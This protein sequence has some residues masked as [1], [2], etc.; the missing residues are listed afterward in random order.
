[1]RHERAAQDVEQVRV[2]AAH[3]AGVA[4]GSVNATIDLDLLVLGSRGY[5]PVRTV[6]LGSVSGTLVREGACSVVVL[7]Q[8]PARDLFA[9]RDNE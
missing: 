3:V 4:R 9:R 1:V 7:P 6:L 2:L 8:V 5:G